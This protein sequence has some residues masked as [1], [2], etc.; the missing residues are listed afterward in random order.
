MPTKHTRFYRDKQH[1]K[2]AGVAAGIAD[3][4]GIDTLIIR[5]GLVILLFA[6]S[7][8]VLPA[9]ILIAMFAPVK[10]NELYLPREEQKFWQGVRAAP[11]R[12]AREVKSRYRAIDRRLA[13]LEALYTSRNRDLANEIENLR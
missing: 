2:V 8:W 3:Y 1:K 6:S 9:Y 12:S 10:P 13:D 7:G 11:G 5:I 4:T